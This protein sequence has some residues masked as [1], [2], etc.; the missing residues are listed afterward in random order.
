MK[1]RGLFSVDVALI[2][3]ALT[4]II[5]GFILHKAGHFD[6]HEVWHGWAVA[7]IVCSVLMLVLVVVHLYAHWGWY[8]SLVNGRVEGKSLLT[9]LLS[10]LFF[11]VVVSGVAMLFM[12]FKP[13]TG[14][15]LW[16]Y[17]IGAV[18]SVVAIAHI[19]LR[20]KMLLKLNKAVKK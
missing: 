17:I 19:I 5:S 8:K 18:L 15:G 12:S 3:C 7:H 1:A 9:A 10:V 4:T 6:A 2:P 20:W 11:V 16:H 13:N 14:L